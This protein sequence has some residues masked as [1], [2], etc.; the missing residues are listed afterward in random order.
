MSALFQE[1]VELPQHRHNQPPILAADSVLGAPL[2]QAFGKLETDRT[3]ALGQLGPP[4]SGQKHRHSGA[5]ETQAPPPTAARGGRGVLQ[6]L[7]M[8]VKPR[9]RAGG[10]HRRRAIT[11]VPPAARSGGAISLPAAKELRTPVVRSGGQRAD[12]ARCG[13]GPSTETAIALAEKV[14]AQGQLAPETK[15]V[16]PTLPA[17]QSGY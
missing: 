6:G 14:A 8:R 1:D 4:S 15:R 7:Q 5:A 3:L 9:A 12:S 13:R 17:L 11:A 2:L 16:H 10:A